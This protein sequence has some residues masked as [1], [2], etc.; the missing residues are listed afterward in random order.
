MA[1]P[2]PLSPCVLQICWRTRT[3]QGQQQ[4]QRQTG[5]HGCPASVPGARAAP[6][7][8][9]ALGFPLWRQ[10]AWQVQWTQQP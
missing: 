3:K 10:D 9:A 5:Q 2:L 6:I 7:Q 8:L 4:Q 1:W